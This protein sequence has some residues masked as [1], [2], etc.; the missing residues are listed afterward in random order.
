MPAENDHF[1]PREEPSLDVEE[2][3]ISFI[4]SYKPKNGEHVPNNE[5]PSVEV[6]DKNA[7]ILNGFVGQSNPLDGKRPVSKEETL[8]MDETAHQQINR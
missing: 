8:E 7:A 5:L 1:S 6:I 4:N 3:K 2:H